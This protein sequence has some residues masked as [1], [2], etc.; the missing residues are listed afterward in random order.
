MPDPPTDP[1]SGGGGPGS[2]PKEER[3]G[4]RSGSRSGPLHLVPINRGRTF[5]PEGADGDVVLCDLCGNPMLDRNCKLE[6]RVCGYQRDC[7]DP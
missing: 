5:P 3:T 4:Y 7:S 1:R 2:K 6:C